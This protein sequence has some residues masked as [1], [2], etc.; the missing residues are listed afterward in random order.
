MPTKQDITPVQ[1]PTDGFSVF[2]S[3]LG[4]VAVAFNALGISAVDLYDDGFGTRFTERF[5]RPASEAD[6]PREWVDLIQQALE[7]GQPLALPIDFDS[8]T[9]FQ[10]QV[11]IHTAAIPRG[12]TRSYGWLA[13]RVGRPRAA[14]AIG[15]SMAANPV[16][17]IIPCHRVIRSDGNI[18]HYGIGGADNKRKLLQ[19]ERAIE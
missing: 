6:P 5:H 4:P 3:P 2:E 16:P 9:S 7:V 10:K 8:V 1:T 18:G 19:L 13:D 14:R 17:L 12:Q 15:G 11:L